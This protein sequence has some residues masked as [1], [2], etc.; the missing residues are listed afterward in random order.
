MHNN[1]LVKSFY[2]ALDIFYECYEYKLHQMSTD[3]M[4]IRS[5]FYMKK[6]RNEEAVVLHHTLV[7]RYK[8]A[9]NVM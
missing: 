8:D 7:K 4:E 2:N 3:G 6:M 5:F 9:G 1:K